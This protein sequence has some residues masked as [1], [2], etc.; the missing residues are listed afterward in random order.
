MIAQIKQTKS[1]GLTV[2]R[3]FINDA[4]TSEFLS[5]QMARA[6]VLRKFPSAELRRAK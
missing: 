6:F 5:E 3:V 2:W 4:L 1:F